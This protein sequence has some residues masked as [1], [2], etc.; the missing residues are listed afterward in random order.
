MM[1][2][3]SFLSRIISWIMG[4]ESTASCELTHSEKND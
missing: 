1:C 3:S 4:K 2:L